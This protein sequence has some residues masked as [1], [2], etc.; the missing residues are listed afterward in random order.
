M[1]FS[2]TR[3]RERLKKLFVPKPWGGAVIVLLDW[4]CFYQWYK[5]IHDGTVMFSR[6][7]HVHVYWIS[8]S[9]SPAY[10]IFMVAI[11]TAGTLLFFLGPIILILV[12]TFG[13]EDK[14]PAKPAP[15]GQRG[16]P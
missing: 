7:R 10:F 4:F 11:I 9:D 8:Y 13:P 12:A 16:E 15:L 2:R 14:V 3:A 1:R 6:R 5:I